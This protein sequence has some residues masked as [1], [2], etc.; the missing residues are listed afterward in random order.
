MAE[1][2]VATS[3]QALS[4]SLTRFFKLDEL[5]FTQR[6]LV[7]WFVL[8]A[9]FNQFFS[10]PYTEFREKLAGF[11]LAVNLCGLIGVILWTWLY[12]K[13]TFTRLLKCE[14][15]IAVVG[16]TSPLFGGIE[17]D[18]VFQMLPVLLLVSLAG[19]IPAWLVRRFLNWRILRSSDEYAPPERQFH[20]GRAMAWTSFIAVILVLARIVAAN[21]LERDP[22]EV[23]F[24][25][26]MSVIVPIV[27]MLILLPLLARLRGVKLFLAM[28]VLAFAIALSVLTIGMVIAGSPP[29]EGF[30]LEVTAWFTAAGWLFAL[31]ATHL[32]RRGLIL[33]FGL[34]PERIREAELEYTQEAVLR[35]RIRETKRVAS[36]V[37]SVARFLHRQIAARQSRLETELK[38]VELGTA[39]AESSS[40]HTHEGGE[41]SGLSIGPA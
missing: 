20:I 24:V 19:M 17:P 34:S 39:A 36:W 8:F 5:V 29:P 32:R 11:A 6:I 9:L 30:F 35:R 25:L 26:G 21:V 2:T 14:L 31:A 3:T 40:K 16:I 18:D 37:D 4:R 1:K 15:L 38:N 33:A 28:P 41:S 12:G 27:P 23:M 7:V 13:P 10:G 22:S